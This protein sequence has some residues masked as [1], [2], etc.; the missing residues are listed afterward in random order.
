MAARL[1]DRRRRPRRLPRDRAAARGHVRDLEPR[2]VDRHRSCVRISASS[3]RPTRRRSG[4]PRRQASTSA[5]S[6]PPRDVPPAGRPTPSGESGRTTRGQGE[7]APPGRHAGRDRLTTS[8]RVRRV[9][10][11]AA[12]VSGVL[13]AGPHRCLFNGLAG[14]H[15]HLHGSFAGNHLPLIR[16]VHYDGAHTFPD[17]EALVPRAKR[18]ARADARRR[19]RAAQNAPLEDDEALETE[20]PRPRPRPSR[21]R[22]VGPPR[23]RRPAV[24]SRDRTSPAPSAARSGR[25]TSPATCAPC[26]GSSSTRR[27]GSRPVPSSSSPGS[28]S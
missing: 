11:A 18:T 16:R 24:R 20:E 25:S 19:Y 4:P 7:A 12:V 9:A 27:S 10:A 22:S 23:R 28:S 8:R 3:P 13:A 15:Q 1:E 26:H 17:Q 5:T 2:E 21:P 6:P 14:A